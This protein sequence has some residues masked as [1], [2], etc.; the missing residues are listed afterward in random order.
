MKNEFF[1]AL[2]FIKSKKFINNF[3][4]PWSSLAPALNKNIEKWVL[5]V[6]YIRI[7]FFDLIKIVMLI[8]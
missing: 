1:F 7:F 3:K 4:V 8:V 6:S 2:E 5:G